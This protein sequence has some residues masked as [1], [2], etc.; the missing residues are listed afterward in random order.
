[1]A[2]ESGPFFSAERYGG[3]PGNKLTARPTQPYNVERPW[4]KEPALEHR[5]DQEQARVWAKIEAA[6]Q[7]APG[8]LPKGYLE[9]VKAGVEKAKRQIIADFEQNKGDESN[10]QSPTSESADQ[11]R[12]NAGRAEHANLAFHNWEHS[13]GVIERTA[14]ILDSLV[15][16][17]IATNQTFVTKRDIANA[18]LTSA[19]HDTVQEWQYTTTKN[20]NLKRQRLIKSNE[21]DS[22]TLLLGFM[23]EQNEIAEAKG[24]EPLFNG[25]D[26]SD[27]KS[28]TMRTVPEFVFVENPADPVTDPTNI[29]EIYGKTWGSIA[30]N[31]SLK[32]DN[33][34]INYVAMAVAAADVSIAAIAGKEAFHKEGPKLVLEELP[35]LAEALAN[36]ESLSDGEIVSLA[37]DIVKPLISGQKG[38]ALGKNQLMFRGG[39]VFQMKFVGGSLSFTEEA[40]KP[41]MSELDAATQQFLAEQVFTKTEESASWVER[42]H[43]LPALGLLDIITRTLGAREQV[44]NI[45]AANGRQAFYQLC[46]LLNLR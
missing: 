12:S 34:S 26:Y 9:A 35:G 24:Y 2:H 15:T 45:E 36:P 8:E 22:A 4:Q 41:E 37:Q 14:T 29:G 42:E 10:R 30:H 44:G 27:A 32:R 31:G 21:A 46:E 40:R 23:H 20:N 18:V 6:L 16:H 5:L 17:Q 13:L 7:R 38:F 43:I 39:R 25:S 3:N 33:G 1:M 28:A 19:F 11:A